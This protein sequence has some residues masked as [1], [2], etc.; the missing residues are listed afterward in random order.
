MFDYK[1]SFKGVAI[2]I[3]ILVAFI[4]FA[5]NAIVNN[6]ADANLIQQNVQTQRTTQEAANNI[7]TTSEEKL[8]VV[9]DEQTGTQALDVYYAIARLT[10]LSIFEYPFYAIKNPKGSGYIG[11]ISGIK[12]PSGS[13]EGMAMF[14]VQH[15]ALNQY[16]P[17][18]EQ[19]VQAIN[20]L[21]K[22]FNQNIEYAGGYDYLEVKGWIDN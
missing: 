17:E 3:I 12:S 4:Y 2:T 6:D 18:I 11:I 8:K 21:A 9:I 15:K 13:S 16:K 14:L 19:S 7:F 10:D 1:L 20:G 5:S 22:N